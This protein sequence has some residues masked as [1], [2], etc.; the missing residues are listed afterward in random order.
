MRSIIR[1]CACIVYVYDITWIAR[2]LQCRDRRESHDRIR[3]DDS[4]DERDRRRRELWEAKT[5]DATTL[6]D[7]K[8]KKKKSEKRKTRVSFF[9]FTEEEKMT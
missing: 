5:P 2:I 8:R 6:F 1:A 4:Y 3:N 9:L 7:K